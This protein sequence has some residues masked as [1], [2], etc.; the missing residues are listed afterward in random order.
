[1]SHFKKILSLFLSF[2]ITATSFAAS[3]YTLEKD[4]VIRMVVFQEPDLS[5]ESQIGKSGYVSFQLIGNVKM[6]GKSLKQ[7]ED[8]IKELYEK[9]Y[10]R[11]AQVNLSIVKY[12]EKWVSVGGDVRRPGTIKYPEDGSL[13]L[14]SAIAQAGDLAETADSSS[15]KVRSK[16]GKQRS[17]TLASSGGVILRHGDSVIVGRSSLSNSS[18]TVSGHVNRPGL[19]DFPKNGGMDIVTAIAQAGGFGRIANRKE[20]GVRRGKQIFSINLRDIEGGKAKM[21]YMKPGDTI[22][23][24]ESR[25]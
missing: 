2:V 5:L 17:Y 8:E 20:V 13:D 16:S 1:M 3:D 6:V 9:D 7:A 23:V 24:R 19:V 11:N 14:R 10:L 18:L 4:D 12:A 22:I 21:F 15:I 25:F